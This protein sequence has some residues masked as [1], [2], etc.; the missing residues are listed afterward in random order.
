[1]KDLSPVTLLDAG[2]AMGLLVEQFVKRGV[3]AYGIDISS[4]AISHAPEV[5]RDRLAVGSLTKSLPRHYDLIT[6]IEVIEHLPSADGRIALAN[7]C[8]ATDRVLFS[9]VPDGYEEPT[10][11]NVQPPEAWSA[12]FADEGFIRAVEYDASYLAP[13][14]VLYERRA[15]T[16]P[17]V[18]REYDRALARSHRE[19]QQLRTAVLRQAEQLEEAASGTQGFKATREAVTDLQEQLLNMRDVVIGLEAELGEA[20]GRREFYETQ[21]ASSQVVAQRYEALTSTRSWRATRKAVGP[22]RRL[23]D[24]LRK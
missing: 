6:C 10:H 12:W 20:K 8:D 13:W 24:F 5:V 14:A 4:F 18:V 23:R 22:L 19:I 16:L 21:L 15:V 17:G 3:D 2:C 7:I 11:V 9:S 1:V